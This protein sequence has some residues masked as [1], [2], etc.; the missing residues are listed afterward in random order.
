LNSSNNIS[1]HNND[2]NNN[3]STIKADNEDR[4]I[5]LSE[6]P[7][8][9]LLN[10]IIEAGEALMVTMNVDR[11]SLRFERLDQKE[12]CTLDEIDKLPIVKGAE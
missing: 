5:E 3:L 12:C 1:S 6:S 2:I 10:P 7:V 4:T 9:R 8:R 11:G